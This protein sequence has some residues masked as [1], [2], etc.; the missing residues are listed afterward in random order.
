MVS[1]QEYGLQEKHLLAVDCVIFGYE[2]GELKL[3][4]FKRQLEPEKGNWSLIGGWVEPN[5]TVEQAAERVLLKITGLSRIFQEEVRVFSAPER[6]PGGRVVS[7]A[8]YA[9]ID[10]KSH[11]KELVNLYDA[12]WW[13]V[14]NLPDLIFDHGQMVAESLAKLR[15][16]ASYDLVGRDL[17][18]DEFTLTQLR[19]LYNSIFSQ[20]F[21]PGNFRKKI[22]SLDAM[23]RLDK[24]DTGESK[25][26][27]FYYTFKPES[28]MNVAI[29]IINL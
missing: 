20:E 22:L 18:P 6:D 8:F 7:I 29:R 27:A 28:E 10:I 2:R 25:K 17:L 16:K 24:K 26:G 3:L 21:D 11:N 1:Q 14:S 9:L 5:E 15:K 12:K 13:P 4:L 23:V 19:Q